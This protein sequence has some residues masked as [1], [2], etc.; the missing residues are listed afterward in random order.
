[1]P[2]WLPSCWSFCCAKTMLHFFP[3]FLVYN[4]VSARAFYC[5]LCF[6]T[7]N[8]A[9]YL[10][11]EWCSTKYGFL[12]MVWQSVQEFVFII[13]YMTGGWCGNSSDFTYPI[14]LDWSN[15]QPSNLLG[16][17]YKTEFGAVPC[18]GGIDKSSKPFIVDYVTLY[19]TEA[20]MLKLHFPNFLPASFCDELQ[21]L[22]IRHISVSPEPN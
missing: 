1:M 3:Y 22:W 7:V 19:N 14:T 21:I 11:W 9:K 15:D 18:F 6:Q 17:N 2:A 20:G 12:T 10:I 5:L 4:S 13:S 16:R 8:R